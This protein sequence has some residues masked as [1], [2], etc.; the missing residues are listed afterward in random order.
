MKYKAVIFDLFGTLVG[1]VSMKERTAVLR[2]M[3]EVLGVPADDFIR[4]WFATF[5]ERDMGVFESI[6]S[7]LEYITE[8][9]GLSADPE[10]VRHSASLQNCFMKQVVVPRPEALEVVSSLKSRGYKVGLISGCSPE[11][12]EIFQALPLASYFDTTI[13]SCLYKMSK[14]DPRIY[15]A[16][17]T[18]LK[19]SPD[20]CLYVGDGDGREL[21]GAAEAGMHPVLIYDPDEKTE[22]T[23]R[24]DNEAAT[25]K[26]PVITSLKMIFQFLE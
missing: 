13:F 6:E 2:Q 5:N 4:L 22:D 23:F 8:K 26:G 19:V 21:T 7:N 20:E 12:P 10:R 14:P 18:L 25:W 17:T 24:V 16:A 1:K 3:A 11:I 15:Q 9:F